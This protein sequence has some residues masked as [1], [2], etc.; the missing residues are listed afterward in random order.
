MT[1]K[2]VILHS[3][4]LV[5]FLPSVHI[6]ITVHSLLKRILLLDRIHAGGSLHPQ[7]LIFVVSPVPSV[8]KWRGMK[9]KKEVIDQSGPLRPQSKWNLV[10]GRD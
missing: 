2:S 6:K 5:R 3:E 9:V 7:M 8:P 1:F 10:T 4:L